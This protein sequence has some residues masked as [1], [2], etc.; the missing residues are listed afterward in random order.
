[1]GDVFEAHLDSVA[2]IDFTTTEVWTLRGRLSTFILVVMNLKTRR[3]EIA[4]VTGAYRAWVRQ[5]G[6]NLTDGQDGFLSNHSHILIDRDTKFLLFC[7]FLKANTEI[8]PGSA[9]TAKSQ[10]QCPYRAFYAEPKI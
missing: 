2:A 10:L 4:G 3:I 8:D 1:M 5:M 9:A 6:R 7:D